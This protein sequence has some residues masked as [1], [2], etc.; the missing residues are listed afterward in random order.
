MKYTELHLHDHYSVLDGLNTP[1]EYMTRAV[2]LGMTHL[3]QTN[4]G[5]LAGHR[6]FQRAAKEAG[7]IPILGVEAYISSTDRFDRRSNVKRSDGTSVYNHIGLLAQNEVGL[8]NL[9]KMSA[10]AWTTGFYS[11]PRMDMDLLEEFNEGVIVLSGCM[12]GLISKSLEAGNLERALKTAQHI[13][14]IYQD[15]F[16]IE[17]Q[18][19]NPIELNKGLYE[20]AEKVKVPVVVT[21]DCH[22]ARKEDLWLEEAMLILSLNP[23]A[24]SGI[25]FSVAQKMDFIE[26]FNYL[27][28]DRKMTFQEIEIYL[29]SA[30]E[31]HNLLQAQGFDDKAITNTQIVADMIGEYPY[32]T[33]LDLLPQ[34]NIKDKTADEVLREKVISGMRAR[35]H[36]NDPERIAHVEHELEIIKDKGFATY[37]LI[38]ADGVSFARQV[39]I[40]VGPGRGSAVAS[41]VNYYLR[42]TGIDPLPYKLEFFRF[43]D[44][45]RPDWPDIDTDL[46]KSRRHEVKEYMNRTYHNTANIATYGYFKDNSSI[47]DAARVFKV[48]LGEVNLILKSV[49]TLDGFKTSPLTLAFRQKYPEVLKLAEALQGRIRSVGMHAGGLVVSKQP[50]EDYVPM[51]SASDTQDD[52]TERVPVVGYDMKDVESIGMIKFDWLGLTT[53]SVVA[54]TI[55]A[56]HKRGISL[57]PY[58]IPLDDANVYEM[59]SRGQTKGVFQCEAQ[60]YTKTIIDMGGVQNFNDLVASNALVRPG[61]AN[62]SI[63]ANYIKGKQTGEFEYIHACTKFFTEDTYGQILFQEQSMRLCVELAGLS[64]QD[65]NE[66][67]RAIGK[68]IHDKLVLWKD[69]FIDGA[70]E[71]IGRK[72]AEEVWNDLEKSA[73][74][75]FNKAHSVGYSML[76][77]W[78]AWLKYHYPLEFMTAILN[79]EGDK[80]MRLDYLME[81]KRLGI[82]IYLP[83]VNL[84]SIKNT[85]EGDGIRLGLS[86][87]KYISG[88]VG[89]KII[90]RR[91]YTSYEH[92]LKEAGEK[93]SG[94]NSRAIDAMNKVGSAF[95]PDNP[96]NGNERDN[97]YEYLDIPA[98]DSKALDPE[99]EVQFRSLAEYVENDTFVICG[100]A[101]G[102]KVGTGWALVDFVDETGST[103]IFTDQNTPIEKGKMYVVLVSNNR[104]CRYATTDDIVMGE[105]GI[106]G[107]FLA[108]RKLDLEDG[109]MRCIHYKTRMT[110]AGKK[111]ANAIFTDSD[112]TLYSAMVFGEN[113]DAFMMKCKASMKVYPRFSEKEDGALI[114]QELK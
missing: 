114:L 43:L 26:R 102:I 65:A 49:S 51:Q 29:R 81:A 86:S 91:P 79:N 46:E 7:I 37:F 104:I 27:Y 71:K 97:F 41:F 31:Q 78:T 55:D 94:I 105:G 76:S 1:A 18:G 57:D 44:P 108:K 106:L 39:G 30:S 17:V 25:D 34:P 101:R 64:M 84:S 4:H 100:M 88:K 75:Q 93:G 9:N 110:K 47:R 112:K 24:R 3:A 82:K 73:D 22:Y 20:I 50:I 61:A 90:E 45:S 8:R 38:E 5:T 60:P 13:K 40:L 67:R 92:L 89:A 74:Y 53:L 6:E 69:R 56:L 48:P 98:F 72:R 54:E 95:F 32:W 87:I 77:Y 113:V 10:E 109:Q 103:S 80:N 52:S 14:S 2:E 70:A 59:L 12:S 21:S 83:H 36:E 62:S 99:V 63:G 23:K 58:D 107:N 28:P 66:I 19:H 111:M 35:G 16:F 11:K 96:K 15:R 33:N 42:V 68:K 85:I